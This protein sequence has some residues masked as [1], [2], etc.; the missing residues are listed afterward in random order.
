MLHNDELRA[1]KP[2]LF[3]N[4]FNGNFLIRNRETQGN[5]ELEGDYVWVEFFLPYYT[6]EAKGNF[7][8]MGK[9]T[10][11]RMNRNSKM[12]YNY[13]RNG[14]EAKL[15]LKQGFYNYMYVLS[16]DAKRGGDESITEG[17]YWDT[18]NDYYIY[19]YHRKFGTYYD[20]LLGVKKLNSL[21]K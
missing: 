15:Y 20:Q 2:Y 9:L 11:W 13:T 3:Y 18:E 1:N 6:P 17:S 7:Y 16:N 12:T 19:V 21:K 8:V 10:D 5:P 14:Y 4:D